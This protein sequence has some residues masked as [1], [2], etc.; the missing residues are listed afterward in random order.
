MAPLVN[1]EILLRRS[2]DVTGDGVVDELLLLGTPT[3]DSPFIQNITVLMRNGRTGRI[4][5]V[6]P[7]E[8]GGYDPTLFLCDFTGDGVLDVKLSIQSGGSGGFVFTYVYSFVRNQLRQLFSGEQYDASREF[9]ANYADGFV[10]VVED[11]TLGHTFRVDVKNDPAA[12]TLYNADG[13]L[14]EPTEA[15]VGPFIA[16]IPVILDEESGTCSLMALTR[17]WGTFAAD[18]VGYLQDYL[19]WDGRS[20]TSVR[21]ELGIFPQ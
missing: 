20:F 18:T 15:N 16:A 21:E 1:Q 3:E 17:V 7:P 2:G 11:I 19:S 13:S 8:N 5:Q 4:V 12:A 6:S 10:I 14:K 9:R